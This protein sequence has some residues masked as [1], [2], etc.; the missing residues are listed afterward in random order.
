MKTT[1]T[2]CPI[3]TVFLVVTLVALATPCSFADQYTIAI[4]PGLNLIANQLDHGSNSLSEVMPVVPNGCV[5]Y[6]YD[7]AAG[8]YRISSFFD[9][10]MEMATQGTTTLGPGDGAFLQSPTNFTLTFSG[11]PHVPALPVSIPNDKCYLLSRQ[12]NGPGTPDNITGLTFVGGERAY[13]WDG[14]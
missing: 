9:V 14:S 4:K 8:A 7:N 5:L 1:V 12:T 3:H 13:T 10:W 6:K 2:H 11:A